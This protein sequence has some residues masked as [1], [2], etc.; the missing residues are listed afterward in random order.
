[1]RLCSRDQRPPRP[2]PPYGTGPRSP[3]APARGPRAWHARWPDGRLYVITDNLAP[4][5]DTRGRRHGPPATTLNWSSC[6]PIRPR[7]SDPQPGANTRSTLHDEA[8]AEAGQARP[9][10]IK[11]ATL[12]REHRYIVPGGLPARQ[13]LP[14]ALCS[15]TH[16]CRDVTEEET[17]GGN[18]RRF[19]SAF[20]PGG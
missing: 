5:T 3:T 12:S 11:V 10:Q 19:P 16:G 6:P 13:V 1:M 18:W 7:L 2:S 14:L 20:C 9:A 4:C 15:A 17:G 8:L